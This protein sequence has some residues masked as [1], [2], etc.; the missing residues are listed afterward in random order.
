M[1][2]A[3]IWKTEWN[4]GKEWRATRE[5]RW[6]RLLRWVGSDVLFIYAIWTEALGMFRPRFG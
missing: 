6:K 1:T 3:R 4:T 5:P 2:D